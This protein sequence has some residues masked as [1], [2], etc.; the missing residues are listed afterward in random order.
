MFKKG[1]ILEKGLQLVYADMV[2]HV[3][4][5][6]ARKSR[7]FFYRGKNISGGDIITI[8]LL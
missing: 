6:A 7:K 1:F 3:H 4:K 5:I 8:E 2:S